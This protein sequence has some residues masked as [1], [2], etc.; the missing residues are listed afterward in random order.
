MKKGI[1][2]KEVA[3]GSAGDTFG[4]EH[5]S[6]FHRN[7]LR[8]LPTSAVKRPVKGAFT[9]LDGDQDWPVLRLLS[10]S[11][12]VTSDSKRHARFFLKNMMS[13]LLRV[14]LLRD[15]DFYF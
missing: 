10:T 7:G 12:S 5:S 2:A 13:W 3:G 9:I 4:P 14:A 6:T 11:I 15:K 8:N 1:D